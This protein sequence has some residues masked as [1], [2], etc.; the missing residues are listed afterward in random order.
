MRV[1]ESK[2]DYLE[3]AYKTKYYVIDK[4]NGQINA[5]HD[6]SLELKEFKGHF[7]PFNLDELEMKVCR[8]VDRNKYEDDLPEPQDALQAQD[9]DSNSGSQ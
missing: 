8:L 7:S 9:S 5:I 6:D 4:V 3:H 1:L 2:M